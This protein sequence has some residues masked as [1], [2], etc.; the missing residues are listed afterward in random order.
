MESKFS[1]KSKKDVKKTQPPQTKSIQINNPGLKKLLS[2]QNIEVLNSYTQKEFSEVFLGYIY[3]RFDYNKS[4][5]SKKSQ[6][7]RKEFCNKKG[8]LFKYA[9][10]KNF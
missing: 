9:F 6:P 5:F 2:K 8:S 3:S 1:F 7:R 10:F 4:N